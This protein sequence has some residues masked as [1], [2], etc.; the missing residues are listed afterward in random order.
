[1]SVVECCVLNGMEAEQLGLPACCRRVVLR[2]QVRRRAVLATVSLS[3][4]TSSEVEQ[5]KS[6]VSSLHACACTNASSFTVYRS[7][8]CSLRMTSQGSGECL[9]WF[10][11]LCCHILCRDCRFWTP[12]APQSNQSRLIALPGCDRMMTRY[13][14]WSSYWRSL[15]CKAVKAEHDLQ[16]V[17][18]DEFS[19][20]ASHLGITSFLG[21]CDA[22]ETRNI[23]GQ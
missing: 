8:G 9:N 16:A 14:C 2:V 19:S 23:L 18:L 7:H 10:S 12:D 20:E 13:F 15:F 5:S 6:A 21:R 17:G 1:M 3:V 11:G 22:A 4:L